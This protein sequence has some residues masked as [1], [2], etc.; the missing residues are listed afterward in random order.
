MSA[1]VGGTIWV[2]L[3]M[4]L[5]SGPLAADE[6][7]LIVKDLSTGQLREGEQ[8]QQELWIKDMDNG[9]EKRLVE[10][11]QAKK[12][13]DR[14]ENILAPRFSQDKTHV[15]FQT[16]A[17]V[18]SAALHIVDL[19][20]GEEH[21]VCSANGYFLPS[22]GPYSGKIIANQHRYFQG[23]GSYD[24]WFALNND[25]SEIKD[26]GPEFHPGALPVKITVR[27]ALLGKS[28]VAEF[29]NLTKVP[30]HIKVLFNRPSNGDRKT[31][32]LDVPAGGMKEFGHVE[33]W[34]LRR[35]DQIM[36]S[37]D[38]YPATAGTVM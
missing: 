37:N 20:S 13:Q 28:Q 8:R 17:F 6:M 30:L 38:D 26:L 36:A 27:P 2:V 3:A 31:V 1:R 32:E 23:G 7:K 10:P 22:E 33:G 12:P 9:K 11:N 5:T 19:T 16:S 25:G 34:P 29:H 35:G 18:T 15:Y 4:A 21:Y 14:I 24:H